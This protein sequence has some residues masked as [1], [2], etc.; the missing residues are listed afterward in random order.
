MKQRMRWLD[1]ITDSMGMSL[2]KLQ[3]LVMDREAWQAA[4]HRSQSVR[5]NWVTEL[6]L[7]K[8]SRSKFFFGISLLFLW[9]AEIQS[10]NPV[11]G[12]LISGFSAF[13][14]PNL[15]IWK[16][17]V[18]ILLKPDFKDSEHYIVSIWSEHN[19]TVVWAF[20]GISLLWNWDENWL[21]PILWPLL[22]FL[23]LLA[24]WVQQFHSIIF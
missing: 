22:S 11:V 14:K 5:H 13:C 2:S 24:Y 8:W 10:K 12:N 16:F 3:E 23:N 15:Y 19:C 17:S 4:V 20:F 9:S 1:G 6:N 21:F 18:H 7:T